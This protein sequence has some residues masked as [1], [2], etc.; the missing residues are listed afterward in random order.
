MENIVIAGFARTAIGKYMGIFK[1]VAIDI[2]GSKILDEVIKKENINKND[3]TD[4]ITGIVL[5]AGAGQNIA[6]QIA[7]NSNLNNE[8]ICYN[9]NFV[10]GSS[11]KAIDIACMTLKLKK[12][13]MIAVIGI[14]NM[15][16]A[17]YLISKDEENIDKTNFK[18]S[19]VYDGLTDF[20]TKKKMGELVENLKYK[21]HITREDV[22]KLA[23]MSQKKVINAY[24]N[25]HFEK[26]ILPIE[27]D[28]TI[29]FKD[30]YPRFN[31]EYEKLTKLKP[32]FVENGITTA[33]NSSG[34]NDG[35]SVLI[36]TTKK[37]AIENNLKI[38]AEILD[39]EEVGIEPE[40]MAEAPIYST[41][42]ILKNNNLK[43]NDLDSI[44][45]TEAFAIQVLSFLKYFNLKYDDVNSNGG[46]I[47]L[48]HPIGSNG[49]RI[50]V[51]LLNNMIE[52]NSKLGLA[53]LCIG[54]GN[55]MSILL[56][57]ENYE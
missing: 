40:D 1:N 46:S 8:T 7:I 45:I 27:I 11:M 17:P 51:S 6:R 42:K 16:L 12:S 47:S 20:K 53:T 15:S 14:E 24:N 25:N 34:I 39:L 52:K 22:D 21:Y 38:Y 28:G 35:A 32:A 50:V 9:V 33:G 5:Q 54:G 4:V 30:E 19:V 31:I 56:K 29:Y 43:I 55:G 13:K 57:R 23:Y 41:D 2:L 26:E 44:E 48:G 49:T 18:D 36:L 10:C 3:I 37:Y